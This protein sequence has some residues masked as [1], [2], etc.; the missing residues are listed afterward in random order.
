[1]PIN[2][3]RITHALHALPVCHSRAGG[4]PV[5]RQ[6]ASTFPHAT[7]AGP[8]DSS[9][10]HATPFKIDHSTREAPKDEPPPGGEGSDFGRV[11][12]QNVGV[13]DLGASDTSI[14]EGHLSTS[15]CHR[16]NISYRLG[17]SLKFIGAHE[18]F[19][20]DPEADAMLTRVYHK[21]YVVPEVV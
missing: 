12:G 20:N 17:R 13:E 9:Q 15:L 7:A 5:I 1:M 16:A 8:A 3:P 21:P 19:A 10:N 4:N 14:H 6:E 18:S 2:R 11:A